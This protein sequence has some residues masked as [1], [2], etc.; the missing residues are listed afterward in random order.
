MFLIPTVD[1]L[2]K[3]FLSV[4]RQLLSWY[5]LSQNTNVSAVDS[6]TALLPLWVRC[7]MSDP[8]GTTWFGAENICTGS[9]ISGVKL[10]SITCKGIVEILNM[11][12][13][14][15]SLNHHQYNELMIFIYLLSYFDISFI[16]FYINSKF[17][18]N[19]GQKIPYNFG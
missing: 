2:K 10:Y 6:N 7:D 13:N 9:I 1:S 17:R 19:C 15:P 14:N 5:T 16:G 3:L 8:A 4:L 11:S 12:L 18:I